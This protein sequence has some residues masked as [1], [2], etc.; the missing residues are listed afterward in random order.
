[1]TGL[2]AND[3]KE[4]KGKEDDKKEAPFGLFKPCRQVDVGFFFLFLF[5]PPE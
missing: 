2:Q 5:L 4:E 3:K 1:M